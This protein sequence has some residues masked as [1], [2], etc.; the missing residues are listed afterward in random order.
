MLHGFDYVEVAKSALSG[1]AIVA[2]ISGYVYAH[3][4]HIL[5]EKSKLPDWHTNEM[6]LAGQA[7]R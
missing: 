6:L 4:G 5:L 1:T 2:G 3:D 7:P